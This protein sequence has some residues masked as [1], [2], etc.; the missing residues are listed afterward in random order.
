MG[1]AMLKDYAA[2]AASGWITINYTIDVTKAQKAAPWE[3]SR[4]PRGGI[5]FFPLGAS[6]TAGPFTV[7]QS[8]GS[9]W[10]DDG[11]KT[12]TS[13]SG[14]KLVADGASGWYAYAVGGNLFLKKFADVP[15]GMQAPGNEGEIGLYPGNGFLEFE[16]QGPYTSIAAG[17]S[18]PWKMQWRVAK[19]PSSV[20]VAAGSA[21]LLAFAQQEAG[22]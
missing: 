14:T 5:A 22:M 13:P 8:G 20:T 15:A 19:I 18:L 10:V 2:D 3:V 1:V 17:G 11:P 9:V 16:V 6:V 7:T 4:V 21:S 12:A